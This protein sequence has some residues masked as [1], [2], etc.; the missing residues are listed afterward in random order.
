MVRRLLWVLSLAVVSRNP[1]RTALSLLVGATRTNPTAFSVREI[2]E[3][4]LIAVLRI[5]NTEDQAG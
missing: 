2:S 3:A 4:E 5:P 1:H